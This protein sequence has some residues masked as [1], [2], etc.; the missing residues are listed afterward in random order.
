MF[1]MLETGEAWFMLLR[2]LHAELT[3]CTCTCVSACPRCSAVHGCVILT[4]QMCSSLPR[5]MAIAAEQTVLKLMNIE[6]ELLLHQELQRRRERGRQRRCSVWALSLL[7]Q[8]TC[9]YI[10]GRYPS[11]YGVTPGYTTQEHKS[12]FSWTLCLL[13]KAKLR[14]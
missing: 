6:Y 4:S 8:T 12:D 3:P 14:Q 2:W 13:Q 1:K 11:N 10:P 5:T 9:S 7:K